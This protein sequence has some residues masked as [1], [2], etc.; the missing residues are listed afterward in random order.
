MTAT[1]P[2]TRTNVPEGTLDVV[3]TQAALFSALKFVTTIAGR[4]VRHQ[5]SLA[6]LG[7]V[8]LEAEGGLLSVAMFDYENVARQLVAGTGTGRAL[9]PAFTLF[10]IVK[11]L[12]KSCELILSTQGTKLVLIGDGVTYRLPLLL[13]QDYPELPAWEPG[14]QPVGV[15]TAEQ[16]KRL[17]D[18][19]VAAGR[20]DTLPVLTGVYIHGGTGGTVHF[21]ATDRY[22]L[23]VFDT[24]LPA[25][26]KL[27]NSLV[28]AAVI[29][30]VA[31]FFAKSPAVTIT[32][33]KLSKESRL[34]TFTD[35]ER[36]IVARELDG[37]FPDYP[38]LIPTKDELVTTVTLDAV[39]L[40]KAVKQVAKV[41]TGNRPVVLTAA[42]GQITVAAG[43]ADECTAE[44]SVVGLGAGE[45]DQVGANPNFLVDG[46]GTAGK[47]VTLRF[48]EEA[49]KP[50]LLSD[51]DRDG[52]I[53]LL[54]PVRLG[55]A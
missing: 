2:E 7:G 30:H 54:M 16:I 11:D 12:D 40:T 32:N 19:T 53:Y 8:L 14:S 17:A 55:D 26:D 3:T 13:L 20:D 29:G 37:A 31:R 41:Q 34:T 33:S 21:A 9:V 5:S 52:F 35:G 50:F 6:V 47:M 4:R 38:R 46:V 15:L 49:R 36:T 48:P 1:I 23:V 18:V 27:R 28:P 10:D 39:E 25:A 51:P 22:R 24:G 42:Q 44:K 45:T 43:S